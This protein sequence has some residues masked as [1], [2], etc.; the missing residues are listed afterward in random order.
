MHK[1][2]SNIP[3]YYHSHICT[4]QHKVPP[5]TSLPSLQTAALVEAPTSFPSLAA[6]DVS[7]SAENHQVDFLSNQISRMRIAGQVTAIVH[8]SRCSQGA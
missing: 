1:L 8:R 4:S 3:C 6:L 7:H 5:V 2:L